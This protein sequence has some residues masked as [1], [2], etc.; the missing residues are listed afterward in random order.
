MESR[1]LEWEGQGRRRAKDVP[2]LRVG[3]G[4]V[5]ADGPLGLEDQSACRTPEGELHFPWVLL[6]NVPLVGGEGLVGHSADWAPEGGGFLRVGQL[7]PVG[8]CH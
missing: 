3:L 8:R 5:D 7:D 1:L 2:G 4:V 6:H